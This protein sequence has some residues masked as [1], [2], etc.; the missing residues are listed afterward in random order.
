MGIEKERFPPFLSSH[1]PPNT[2]IFFYLSLFLSEYPAGG[3][4]EERAF[5]CFTICRSLGP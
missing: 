5:G 1:R 4:A 2:Y 3:S